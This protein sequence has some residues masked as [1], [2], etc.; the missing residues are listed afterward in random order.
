MLEEQALLEGPGNVAALVAFLHQ[1]Q[2]LARAARV[3][4][5]NLRACGA[6]K[7]VVILQIDGFY[8]ETFGI[9]ASSAYGISG[10]LIMVNTKKYRKTPSQ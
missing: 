7:S 3:H 8:H 2:K 5:F 4:L 6:C 10:E 9:S 1:E